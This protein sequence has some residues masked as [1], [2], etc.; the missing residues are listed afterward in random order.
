MTLFRWVQRFT[1]LLIDAARPY[2]HAVG[3]R[4][5]VDETYVKVAGVWRYVYRAVDQY[6][7]VIDV[8]VSRARDIAAARR[9]FTASLATH[10][11]PVEVV[12][13]RAAALARVIDEPIPAAFHNTGQYQNKRGE[14]DHGRLR[15]RLRPMQGLRRT[16]PP[17]S[18]PRACAHPEPT[19]RAL[20]SGNRHGSCPAAGHRIRR[21][22][23]G[24]LTGHPVHRGSRTVV[25]RS[26]QQ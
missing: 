26:T 6:G 5:F 10:G 23:P 20:R 3:D 16:A 18:Y 12:T 25:D 11:Q 4:R 13:D 21:A 7:Q 9:F 22:P 24:D 15:A 2:R 8:Y 19:A 14:C 1:P 17:V